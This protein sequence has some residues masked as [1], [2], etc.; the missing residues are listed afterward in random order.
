MD[1]GHTGKELYEAFKIY[2]SVVN[3]WRRLL[4]ETGSLE[5][6]YPKERKGKIDLKKMKAE[7]ERKPDITLPE[8]ALIFGC[9]KQSVHTALKKAGITYKKKLLTTPNNRRR[10]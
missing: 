9:R 1:E 3:D 6:R 8:L 7:L 2:P 4:K 5:P 10:R